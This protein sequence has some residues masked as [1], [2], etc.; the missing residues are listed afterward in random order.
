MV[1]YRLAVVRQADSTCLAQV[2]VLRDVLALLPQ[3]GRCRGEHARQA[4]LIGLPA[5]EAHERG[6]VDGRLGVRHG[7]DG[8]EP[9]SDR[10][11]G[12]R[13][14]GL[15]VLFA[16]F[17][18]VHVQVDKARRQPLAAGVDDPRAV[19]HGPRPLEPFDAAVA[20]EDGAL[21]RELRGRIDHLRAGNGHQALGRFH[22]CS[23]VAGTPPAMR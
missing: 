8:G 1:A 19:R 20:K 14:D 13:R 5:H 2:A 21:L 22:Q 15:L 7:H 16:R 6:V 4:R 23:A 18:Q 17:P 9:A 10:R 11:A 12:A 3:R